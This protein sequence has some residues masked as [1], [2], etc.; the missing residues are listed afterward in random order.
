M[1]ELKQEFPDVHITPYTDDI[2]II[3]P[4]DSLR[5]IAEIVQERYYQIGLSLNISNCLLIGREPADLFIDDQ[6]VS[7]IN[8]FESGFRFLGCYL[9]NHIFCSTELGG[10]DFHKSKYL[11]TAAFICGAK[12]FVF[13][14]LKRF[15]ENQHLIEYCFSDYLVSLQNEIEC[16]SPHIWSKCFPDDIREIPPRSLISLKFAYAKLQKKILKVFENLDF[17][18]RL[19]LAKERNPVFANCLSD[20]KESSTSCL[21]SQ[22]P[23]VYG[24]LLND[25][26]W[27]TALRIRCF[28]WPRSVPNDL[29]CRCGQLIKLNHLFN[30]KF[31]ITYRSVVHDAVRDQLYAMCKSHHIEAFVEPLVRRLSTE[32]EDE[33]TV[34]KRRA[35]LITPGSDGVI[36]VV[37]V[38]TVDDCK[39]S[40]ID[41]ANKDETPLCFAEKSK[42]KQYNEPL[43]QLGRV[44]HVKYQLVIF[45]VSLFGNI[46]ISGIKFL[47]GFRS[48]I[49]ERAK[50][51]LNFNFWHNRM[52]FCILKAIPEMLTKALLQL[53]IEYE[54]RALKRFDVVDACIEDIEF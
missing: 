13:E 14:F 11:C 34:G 19:S 16:I 38:V 49:E 31:N 42:I 12:N 32:N 50:Q 24:L 33:N 36:K 20:L 25:H 10:L 54:N 7:F 29:I 43:S 51:E 1:C 8:Y 22:I 40:A 46:G 30:C 9:G 48:L 21:I 2:S 27:T 44:E 4:I 37:D 52:V 18:V 47:E 45:A 26:Q 6:S 35:D 39:D 17:T 28:L 3:G 53:G 41:F 23:N 5:T 15:P